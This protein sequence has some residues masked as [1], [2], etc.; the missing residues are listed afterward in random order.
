MGKPLLI[1]SGGWLFP[2]MAPDLKVRTL[3]LSL[4]LSLSLL[5]SN[6]DYKSI[7]VYFDFENGNFCP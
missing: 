1:I 6:S 3:S 5:F 2:M 7:F 4:S